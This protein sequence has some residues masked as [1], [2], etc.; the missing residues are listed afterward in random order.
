MAEEWTCGKGLAKNA[1]LPARLGDLAD[2]MAGM[3]EAHTRALDVSHDS[4]REEYDA[5]RR[6]ADSWRGIAPQLHALASQMAGYKGLA[7]GPHDD[8]A[9]TGPEFARAFA[10]YVAVERDVA[11]VVK[12]QL[13]E[14]GPMLDEMR[15][16]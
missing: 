10:R 1:V 3:L 14:Y 7:M 13:D 6:I 9:M 5:Y 15:R 4:C 16:G 8:A 2:A 12:A 11:S